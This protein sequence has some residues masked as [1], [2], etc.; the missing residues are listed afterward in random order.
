MHG[1]GP[2]KVPT[3][4]QAHAAIDA[5]ATL[6]GHA[7][8]VK[9]A[10]GLVDIVVDLFDSPDDQAELKGAYAAARKRTDTALDR[11]DTAIADRLPG[12]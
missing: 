4:Q 3:F 10:S 5:L 2:L 7:D 6:T 9:A 12:G 11:L 8:T 1:V